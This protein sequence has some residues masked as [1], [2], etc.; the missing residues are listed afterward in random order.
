VPAG[1]RV[2]QLASYAGPPAR[3]DLGDSTS[4]AVPRVVGVGGAKPA[5]GREHLVAEAGVRA[6]VRDALCRQ[7]KGSAV[8]VG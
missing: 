5:C 7:K 6:L 3:S 1:G 8:T 2:P 4:A